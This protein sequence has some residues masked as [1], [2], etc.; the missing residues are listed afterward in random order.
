[1]FVVLTLLLRMG[2]VIQMGVAQHLYLDAVSAVLQFVLDI[3][4]VPSYKLS[5]QTEKSKQKI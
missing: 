1:M 4:K 2:Y 5:R 3:F